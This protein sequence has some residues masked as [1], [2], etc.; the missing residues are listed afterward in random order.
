[1]IL[2]DRAAPFAALARGVSKAREA[3]APRPFVHVVEELAALFGRAGRWHGANDR[4]FLDQSG[5]QAEAR[6]LEMAADVAD[7]QR[8][9][10]VRLVT[11]VFEERFLVGDARIFARGSHRFSVRKLLEYAR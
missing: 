7:Q 1:V 10:Q 11:A 5:K 3:L 8:I 2:G 9:A 6:S 4:A